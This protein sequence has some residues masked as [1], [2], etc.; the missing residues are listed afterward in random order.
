MGFSGILMGRVRII[1]YTDKYSVQ[2]VNL[3]RTDRKP[4]CGWANVQMVN[5]L[6][7]LGTSIKATT[8]RD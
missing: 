4:M 2:L 5:F 7:G 1:V 8:E 6:Y 3:Q